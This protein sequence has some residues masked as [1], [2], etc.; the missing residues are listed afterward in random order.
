MVVSLVAAAGLASAASATP[1]PRVKPYESGALQLAIPD[2]NPVGASNTISVTDIGT[3]VDFEQIWIDIDHTWV[4][5]LTFTLTHGSQ[6]CV[7]LDRPGV[8]PLTFGNSDDLVG[9]YTF[10]DAGPAFPE[11]TGGSGFVAPGIY[12]ANPGDLGACF[13][14]MDKFGDWTLTVTDAAAGDVGVV[15]A[16]GFT[17]RNVPTP[18]AGAL[19]G[20]GG[21]VA[22]RRRRH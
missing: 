17:V 8:P 11:T 16:W 18:G 21:L 10:V 9:V 20:L 19:L 15:F 12:G 7:F 4:G 22:T 6:A 13:N 5:D 14:G 1:D 3:V 2:A